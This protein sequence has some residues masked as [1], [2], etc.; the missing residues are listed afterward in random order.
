[1]LAVITEK[2]KSPPKVKISKSN[3]GWVEYTFGGAL[4]GFKDLTMGA[5]ACRDHCSFLRVIDVVRIRLTSQH[6][7][8]LYIASHIAT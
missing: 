5:I 4:A 3:S 7:E 6:G 2:P 8:G 1:M